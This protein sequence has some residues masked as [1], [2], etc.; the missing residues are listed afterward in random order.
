MNTNLNS[1]SVHLIKVHPTSS[2]LKDSVFIVPQN[3]QA[4]RDLRIYQVQFLLF[5]DESWKD[6]VTH[7]VHGKAKIPTEAS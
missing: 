7:T 3:G 1:F 2:N 4:K 6:C 5:Y